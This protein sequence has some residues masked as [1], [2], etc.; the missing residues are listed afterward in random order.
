M[1]APASSPLD[2]FTVSPNFV[3]RV[4]WLF[5]EAAEAGSVLKQLPTTVR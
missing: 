5:A 3:K 2:H 1:S 4:P